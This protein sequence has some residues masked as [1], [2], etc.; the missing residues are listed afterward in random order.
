VPDLAT[1]TKL[2]TTNW[3]RFFAAGTPVADREALLEHGAT[4]HEALVQNSTNP[5]QAQATAKVKKVELAAPDASEAAV[6]YDVLLKG[7]PALV[8]ASGK[9][10]LEVGIWKVAGA[11]F[12][13]LI[14]LSTTGAIPGCS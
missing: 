3:E 4:Y 6:T 7:E 8:D 1:T 9:A 5:L 14:A 12:C 11:S 10:V 2:I 13:A